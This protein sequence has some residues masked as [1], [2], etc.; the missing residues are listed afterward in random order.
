M[1]NPVIGW[2]YE[3]AALTN[4][5]FTH[6]S[7]VSTAENPNNFAFCLA[8]V[9]NTPDVNQRAI[10]VH[11]LCGFIRRQKDIALNSG[12]SLIRYQK[13]KTIPVHGQPPGNIFRVCSNRDEMARTQFDQEPLTGKPIERLFERIPLRALQAQFANELLESGSRVWKLANMLKYTRIRETRLDTARVLRHYGN[14]RE[15]AIVAGCSLSR[16]A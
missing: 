15:P 12:N 7:D 3:V 9:G 10:A 14:Y 11:A 6:H 5:K 2:N 16:S 13:P 8:L 1:L 4:A